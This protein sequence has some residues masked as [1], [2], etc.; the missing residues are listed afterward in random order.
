MGNVSWLLT[1]LVLA[2][3]LPV[4]LHTFAGEE[5]LEELENRCQMR[6]PLQVSVV[7]SGRTSVRRPL[8]VSVVESVEPVSDEVS[9]AEIYGSVQDRRQTMVLILPLSR[10]LWISSR[11]ETDNGTHTC[12]LGQDSDVR[13]GGDSCPRAGSESITSCSVCGP[14]IGTDEMTASCLLAVGLVPEVLLVQSDTLDCTYSLVYRTS[15]N[16]AC[17]TRWQV[18]AGPSKSRKRHIRRYS[19]YLFIRPPSSSSTLHSPVG[20]SGEGNHYCKG[21]VGSYRL[22]ETS[23]F[24]TRIFPLMK[25]QT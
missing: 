22:N 9:S 25:A 15:W 1:G 23:R 14:A 16:V 4:S 5:L 18:S 3:L 7:E 12:V 19:S 2:C 8:Q 13:G 6:C 11:Q 21:G 10:D 17:I 24:E 20:G